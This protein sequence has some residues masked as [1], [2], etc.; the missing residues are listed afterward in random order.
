MSRADKIENA[1]QNCN[2]NLIADFKSIYEAL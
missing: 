1:N 2:H